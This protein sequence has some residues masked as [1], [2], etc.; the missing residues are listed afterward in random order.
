MFVLFILHFKSE[1]CFLAVVVVVI[2][3]GALHS[4]CGEYYNISSTVLGTVSRFSFRRHFFSNRP[5]NSRQ[6]PS[7]ITPHAYAR[8]HSTLSRAHCFASLRIDGMSLVRRGPVSYTTV[9]QKR[10]TEQGWLTLWLS[11]Q[12][13]Y[14]CEEEPELR[15]HWLGRTKPDM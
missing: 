12:C 6:T 11:Y 5:I 4:I 2:V 7:S 14:V 9:T 1:G 15:K 10:I 8:T 3:C 13:V